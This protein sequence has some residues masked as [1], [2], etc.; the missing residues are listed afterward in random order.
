[1]NRLYFHFFLLFFLS[2]LRPLAAQ[3]LVPFF[4]QK[5]A[6][7][8][9]IVLLDAQSGFASA[10]GAGFETAGGFYQLT[11]GKWK[12]SLAFPYSDSPILKV[13]SEKSVYG[14]H[15]RVHDDNWKYLFYHF[16]G[17]NWTRLDIPL[18][19]W[20]QTDYVIIK[21]MDGWSDQD[22]WLAGQKATLLHYKNHRWIPVQ[23]PVRWTDGDGDFEK[24]FNVV[25]AV[26]PDDVF[27]AG[28]SGILLRFQ[29]SAGKQ[30]P[31]P[32]TSGILTLDLAP[33]GT[34]WMGTDKGEILNW[35]GKSCRVLTSPK[36]GARIPFLKLLNRRQPAFAQEGRIYGL[37]GDS[38][39]QVLLD[40]SGLKT[41]INAFD[42]VTTDDGS[43]RFTFL[44]VEG[45]Y[46]SAPRG[47]V[48]FRETTAEANIT[49]AARGGLFFDANGDLAPDL[50][51]TGEMSQP[52][53]LLMNNGTGI[54]SDVTFESG[55]LT[56]SNGSLTAVAADFD[57]DGDQDLVTVRT[58]SHRLQIWR[59]KGSGRFSD[60]TAWSGLGEF[61]PA[62]SP[63]YW[64]HSLQSA[65]I[66]L[67][68]DLDLI[69]S[70]W[71]DGLI[72]FLNDGTGRFSRS[73]LPD[74][75]FIN[76][77]KDH[78]IMSAHWILRPDGT[79]AHFIATAGAGSWLGILDPETLTFR[80][81]KT[82][83]KLTV[84]AAVPFPD[85]SDSLPVFFLPDRNIHDRFGQISGDSLITIRKPVRLGSQPVYP[86]FPNGFNLVRD[87]NLD[88]KPD[89]FISTHLLIADSSGYSDSRETNGLSPEGNLTVSDVNGDF[90]PDVLIT[91]GS[92]FGKK[93]TRLWSGLAG[94]PDAIRVIPEGSASAFAGSHCRIEVWSPDSVADKPLAVV[95]PGLSGSPAATS[96]PLPVLVSTA[97]KS[98]VRL[99][100]I[101]PSG[102]D[103]WTDPVSAGSTVTVTEFPE[104]LHSIRLGIRA[105]G[106]LAG[107]L[108]G[109]QELLKLILHIG[110]IWSVWRLMKARDLRDSFLKPV[111]WTGF[112]G[113]YLISYYFTVQESA[114]INWVFPSLAG[115]LFAG[116]G[117]AVTF[118]WKRYLRTN[119]IGPYRIERLIGEG[120]SGKVYEVYSAANKKK[121]AVK[122][123]HART[124]DSPEGQIRFQREVAAGMQLDHPGIVKIHGQGTQDQNRYLTMELV[125]GENLRNWLT[126]DLS[127]RQTVLWLSE[128]A[129][130]LAYMHK[131]GILH[132]DL[133]TENIRV[134]PGLKVKIMDLGLAKTTIF[135]TMTRM[136]TSVGTLAYMSPQQA[137]GMPLDESSD[138]YSLGV[139]GYE[140]LSGGTLPVTGDNDM[141]FVYNIFNQKPLPLQN[142]N[143]EIT[144]ELDS[145]IQ[146]A[147]QKQPEDRFRSASEFGTA[148]KLWLNSET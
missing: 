19:H 59:N 96:E 142:F 69:K 117:S 78:R 121:L 16:D 72:V 109:W 45:I 148:L 90:L 127:V 101:F 131:S 95:Y 75:S 118:A 18:V 73:A 106:K 80:S 26:G 143:Q 41:G 74:Y 3:D 81:L 36:P 147:I 98:K 123:Y 119:Y 114:L 97:G 89:L 1:M 27:I 7:A 9:Q 88:G 64:G 15:H 37:T 35:N 49:A 17:S 5:A 31:L 136:G 145:L 132:R 99:R 84:T 126:R 120:A 58:D 108:V 76:S 135:A 11:G 46:G 110:L 14:L 68:G 133:K 107:Y 113:I 57:N 144:P 44:T 139:I 4:K 104:P 39:W 129:E 124:F 10:C 61:S 52:D 40:A 38:S 111:W 105:A 71:D 92:E 63:V 86:G 146:K 134:T 137:V 12:L 77:K 85:G 29:G 8:S 21:S 65:D 53:L 47:K 50:L 60:V 56:S 67:D 34:L 128:L 94:S 122:V 66:D 28:N 25:K 115:F 54:F 43:G 48:S 102:S 20:D 13:F 55:L 32:V 138:V 2:G 33:D 6:N 30:I 141:A 100:V 112:T 79:W 24:D 23:S 62:Y 103:R 51:L 70:D 87:M 91:Q 140:L 130:A 82:Y 116:T 42:L 125:E 83:P 22:L 93:S